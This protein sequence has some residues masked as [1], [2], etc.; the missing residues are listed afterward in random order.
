MHASQK[1]VERGDPPP[2][3]PQPLEEWMTD[4]TGAGA[5]RKLYAMCKLKVEAEMAADALAKRRRKMGPLVRTG[6]FD[7]YWGDKEW[8]MLGMERETVSLKVLPAAPY[9]EGSRHHGADG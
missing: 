1:A 7:W 4:P 9:L 5:P 3:E 8:R 6:L 2:P